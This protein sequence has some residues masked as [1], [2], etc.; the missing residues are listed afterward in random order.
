MLVGALPALYVALR[1]VNRT[2]PLVAGLVA[3]VALMA[4]INSG[5]WVYALPDLG[6]ASVAATTAARAGYTAS[7]QL[8]YSYIYGSETRFY[9]SLLSLAVS[10]FSLTMLRGEFNRG[11]AYLGILLGLAGVVLGLIGFI[12][13]VVLLSLWFLPTGIKLYRLG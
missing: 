3:A 13:V 5:L 4:D 7:G 8:L 11:V 10:I 9:V 6:N 1:S 12:P 2:W